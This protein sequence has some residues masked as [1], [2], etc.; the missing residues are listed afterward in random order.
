MSVHNGVMRVLGEDPVWESEELARV[1]H[2]AIRGPEDAIAWDTLRD[3]FLGSRERCLAAV[4]A[5]TE[6][7]LDEQLPDPFGGTSDRAELLTILAFHQTYH[8]GQLGL[9]RRIAGLPGA[10]KAPGQ[11]AEVA[12]GAR[13]P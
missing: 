10:I 1:G 9:A 5:L 13:G 4:R 12:A 8:A 6:E 11:E 2:D 7:V 3:R